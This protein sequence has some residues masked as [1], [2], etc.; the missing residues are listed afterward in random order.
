MNLSAQVTIAPNREIVIK[1]KDD[2]DG[3]N[4]E[5]KAVNNISM[6][7]YLHF[8]PYANDLNDEL[9]LLKKNGYFFRFHNSD[10]KI[11]R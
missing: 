9:E 4:D 5:T 8:R 6:G 10:V 7:R 2:L 3:E 1:G 11:I